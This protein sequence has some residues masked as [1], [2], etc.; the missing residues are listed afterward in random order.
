[1]V[2]FIMKPY[3]ENAETSCPN[4]IDGGEEENSAWSLSITNVPNDVYDDENTKVSWFFI[5]FI[6]SNKARYYCLVRDL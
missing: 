3:I 6:L 2:A 5:F 1:M 4:F